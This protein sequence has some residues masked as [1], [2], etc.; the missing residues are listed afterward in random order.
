M[1]VDIETYPKPKQKFKVFTLTATYNQSGYIKNSLDGLAMQ[2]T[3]FTLASFVI[4]DASNDGEPEIIKEWARENCDMYSAR[5][6]ETATASII[7]AS[8]KERESHIFA[9]Y[10]LRKN[11]FENPSKALHWKPWIEQ[12]EYIAY[13]EGDDYWIDP[14]KLQKQVDF[15]DANRDYSM[16]H[17]AF[18]CVD[19]NSQH[20]TID[21]LVKEFS[22][23]MD[24]LDNKEEKERVLNRLRVVESYMEKSESGFVYYK[25]LATS[26]Y[27]MTV[28]VL[29]RKA[30][31]D[32][33]PRN[34]LYFDYGM[35]LVAARLGYVGYLS[36]VTS[37]YRFAPNSVISNPKTL[38]DLGIKMQ[39]LLLYE[40]NELLTSDGLIDDIYTFP[41]YKILVARVLVNLLKRCGL[42][43][44]IRVLF[45][46]FKHLE[47]HIPFLYSL[48]FVPDM[49]DLYNQ[50]R[51]KS[52][53]C[54]NA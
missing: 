2:K 30:V 42:S 34:G 29:V 44:K 38:K 17:T 20:L 1:V 43:D 24:N 21:R 25:L 5:Y 51:Q 9:F 32:K 40:I 12:S 27:I 16:V 47:L 45:L 46:V 11:M 19:K 37:C 54:N 18:Q 36:D 4:D 31:V 22:S 52:Q 53:H 15:L 23:C 10:F 35:F 26:N 28:S 6:V 13:C 7:I 8:L 49:I 41:E 3:D 50:L 39:K 48:V 14:L 33:M